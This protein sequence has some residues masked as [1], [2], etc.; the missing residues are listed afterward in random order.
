VPAKKGCKPPIEILLSTFIRSRS[1]N[2]C[3]AVSVASHDDY[4]SFGL[5]VL[6]RNSQILIATGGNRSHVQ[7]FSASTLL[8]FCG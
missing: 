3:D 7:A 1:S 2:F 5:K 4:G 6:L 8:S